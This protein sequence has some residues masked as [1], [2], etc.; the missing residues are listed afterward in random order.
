MPCV[1]RI[2]DVL[3]FHLRGEEIPYILQR[4]H[5]IGGPDFQFHLP[6][7]DAAHFQD[8][9]DE[10]K[11]MVAGSLDLAEVV[12]C[13]VRQAPILF[14]QGSVAD[15]GIHRR[16]YVMAHVE[17]KDALGLVALLRLGFLPFH[18]QP[19]PHHDIV[20]AEHDEEG[21]DDQGHL[22]NVVLGHGGIDELDLLLEMGFRVGDFP[23]V[24]RHAVLMQLF[25]IIAAEVA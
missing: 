18:V 16:P 4:L 9:V 20:D 19:P 8:I 15:N 25:A 21:D 24:E 13:A 1:H 22:H 17:E 5:E 23:S 6:V 7:L 2:G 10:R 14:H 12:L 11:E 3:G